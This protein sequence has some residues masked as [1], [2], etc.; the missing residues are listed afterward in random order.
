MSTALTTTSEPVLATTNGGIFKSKLRMHFARFDL[1]S[2]RIA[3]YQKSSLWMAFGA[4]GL[5]LSRFTAGKRTLELELGKIA[6]IARGKHGFNKNILDVTMQDGAKHRF[7]L[8]RFDE[9]TA[10]LRDQ[11]GRHG[12]LVSAGAEQWTVRAPASA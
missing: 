12:A 10:Q 2:T 11:L 3:C 9:F 5:I 8:D 4:L 1:T 7:S 6:S